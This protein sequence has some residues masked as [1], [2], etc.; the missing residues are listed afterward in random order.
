METNVQRMRR[1]LTKV[2]LH[3][4]E[5]HNTFDKEA[6]L[7]WEKACE[8]L[9]EMLKIEKDFIKSVQVKAIVMD[10]LNMVKKN[11]NTVKATI[12]LKEK[13]LETFCLN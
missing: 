6:L 13:N 7:M 11:L 9:A 4:D 12:R 10:D 3:A 8:S 5:L 2:E 1:L